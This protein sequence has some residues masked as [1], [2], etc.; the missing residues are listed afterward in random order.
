MSQF[1]HGRRV[2]CEQVFAG[3]SR[4]G[5]SESMMKGTGGNGIPIPQQACPRGDLHPRAQAC[6]GYLR[7]GIAKLGGPDA[8]R[9][10]L[11]CGLG[12]RTGVRRRIV[13]CPSVHSIHL[14]PPSSGSCRSTYNR[15][16][17]ITPSCHTLLPI[18]S[19]RF[20]LSSPN[21][22]VRSTDTTTTPQHQPNNGEFPR[23]HSSNSMTSGLVVTTSTRIAAASARALLACA[24]LLSGWTHRLRPMALRAC[25]CT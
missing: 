21:S 2:N 20:P 14:P 19:H 5:F 22:T 25:A 3:E 10:S 11:E 8:Q 17:V 12:G 24:A 16:S 9:R 4:F 7:R 15:P 23:P 1:C 13:Y 18:H 6:S